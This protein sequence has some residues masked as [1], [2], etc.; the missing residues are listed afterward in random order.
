MKIKKILKPKIL[1]IDDLPIYKD[2]ISEILVD[3]KHEISFASTLEEA[4][5]ALTSKKNESF[6]V[7]LL[8]L[9]LENYASEGIDIKDLG[10]DIINDKTS[11]LI[12]KKVK[13][14]LTS[15]GFEIFHKNDKK[16]QDLASIIEDLFRKNSEILYEDDIR[17]SSPKQTQKIILASKENWSKLIAELSQNT[18][19]LYKMPPRKFEE[20]I[21][22]LLIRD[23]MEV[24]LTPETRDGGRDI[25]AV[26]NTSVGKHLYY[27][28]CKR[29]A[30]TK[31]VDVTLVRAL[32]GVLAAEVA[33]AG[34]IVT[35]S[36]FTKPAI[37][38]QDTIKH[39]LALKDYKNLEEWLRYY[40]R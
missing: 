27:V 21:A 16:N 39:R 24:H 5:R 33:T 28:E 23:G 36:Y 25:L 35:T 22:E 12:S 30:K 17:N 1:I 26:S 9:A 18:E 20:L 2:R 10:T 32:Y 37:K 40:L 38:F 31:P 11:N 15:Q 4:T 34:L 6:D 13:S 3:T 8:D 19:E 7:I 29:Y 14:K